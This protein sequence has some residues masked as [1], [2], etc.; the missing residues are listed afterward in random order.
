MTQQ[1]VQGLKTLPTLSSLPLFVYPANAA[2]GAV[3][4]AFGIRQF[5][6]T[7]LGWPTV[8][9]DQ[10]PPQPVVFLAFSAGCV[11]AIAAAHHWHY[12][13]GTVGAFFAV[14]GWGVPLAAP[15]PVHRLSH[16]RFTHD[17]SRFLGSGHTDFY[18]DPAVSHL[19]LWKRFSQVQGWQV[20]NSRVGAQAQTQA[21]PLHLPQPGVEVR[22]QQLA[23]S[24]QGTFLTAGQFLQTQIEKALDQSAD[25]CS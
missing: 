3:L 2:P 11:G 8:D 15:F 19:E 18:A 1:L 25:H 12:L 20:S 4:S 22:E 17:T 5:L 14:D 10:L 16:D 23:T 24:A 13:G 7:Q 6:L 21:S 9:I